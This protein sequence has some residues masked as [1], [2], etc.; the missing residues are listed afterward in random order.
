VVGTAL[1]LALIFIFG[2]AV[3]IAWVMIA[4]LYNVRFEDKRLFAASIQVIRQTNVFSAIPWTN[5]AAVFID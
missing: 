5:R 1:V 3:W 4:A 2:A